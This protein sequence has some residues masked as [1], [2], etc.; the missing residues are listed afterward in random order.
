MYIVVD[1]DT[2]TELAYPTLQAARYAALKIKRGEVYKVT[3]NGDMP[4]PE[5]RCALFN[6]SNF[7]TERVQVGVI[8]NGIARKTP[9]Q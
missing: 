6:R 5:L 4:N 1:L 9:N 3:L 7:Y 2:L 8:A